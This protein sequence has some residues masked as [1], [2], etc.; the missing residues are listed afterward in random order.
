MSDVVSFAVEKMKR[1]AVMVA[2]TINQI[3]NNYRSMH[4]TVGLEFITK[5]QISY[6]ALIN[7]MTKNNW[8]MSQISIDHQAALNAMVVDILKYNQETYGKGK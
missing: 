3:A 4:D 1:E 5:F 8:D 6:T 7:E 2:A